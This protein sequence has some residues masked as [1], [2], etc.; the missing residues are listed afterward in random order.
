MKLTAVF[1]KTKQ[2]ALWLKLTVGLVGLSLLAAFSLT[3]ARQTQANSASLTAAGCNLFPLSITKSVNPA[4][5]ETGSQAAIQFDLSNLNNKQIDVALLYDI[6]SSMRGQKLADAKT[7]GIA[8]VQAI[9]NVDRTAVLTFDSTA[10]LIQPLT[11]DKTAV[12][13]AINSLTASGGSNLLVGLQL[14]YDQLINSAQH[15]PDTVKAIIVF[16]DGRIDTTGIEPIKAQ[17]EVSRACGIMIYGLGYGSDVEPGA[18]QE[19]ATITDGRYEFAAAANLTTIY[20]EIAIA[21]R[22]I[23]VQD[24]LPVN[25]DVDCN[26]VPVGWQCWPQADGTTQMNY[27]LG[28]ER[29]LANPLTLSFTATINLA[30]DFETQLINTSDTCVAYDGPGNPTCQPIANPPVCI[31]PYLQDSYEPDDAWGEFVLPVSPGEPPQHRNFSHNQDTEWIRT[32]LTENTT[33]TFT[34]QAISATAED[35]QLE[36]YHLL[37]GELVLLASGTNQLT[38]SSS[39]LPPTLTP[40]PTPT[41]TATPTSTPT[42]TP[43]STPTAT[44]TATPVPTLTAVN[45]LPVILHQPP[46]PTFTTRLLPQSPQDEPQYLYLR[47]SSTT[48]QFGC[49]TQY[50]LAMSA[51]PE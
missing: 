4:N 31:Q 6:S 48:N 2:I 23:Q 41:S 15:N 42:A 19:A 14:A 43:T 47:L 40:T 5:P 3:Q 20:Q 25:V 50:E 34:T 24:K 17:A 7:D 36:L 11:A 35:R 44:P 39:T 26:A 46:T 18:M 33:Y 45:Y 13:T 16:S 32:E 49:G 38:W 28:N 21:Q 9:G 27:L 10:H 29:P 8:L 51:A 30:P 22:N 12:T 1:S 37:N